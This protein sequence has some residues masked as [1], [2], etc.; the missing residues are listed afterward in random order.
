MLSIKNLPSYLQ[1]AILC[2]DFLYFNK[3]K[4]VNNDTAT[5]K[6]ITELIEKEIN[7]V[8]EKMP[9]KNKI[10]LLIGENIKESDDSYLN[11]F[12]A[13]KE[14][15]NNLQNKDVLEIISNV[16]KLLPCI[17]ESKIGNYELYTVSDKVTAGKQIVLRSNKFWDLY[18]E[19][20]R[21]F[22]EFLEQA[23]KLEKVFKGIDASEQSIQENKIKL[24]NTF[25]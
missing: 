12:K 17:R 8:I 13:V 20:D 2:D 25:K 5:Y 22:C 23:N 18:Y 10:D 11:F 3:V 6:G 19:T 16:L 9:Q 14:K 7:E 21:V 15:I 24:I 4:I 1:S